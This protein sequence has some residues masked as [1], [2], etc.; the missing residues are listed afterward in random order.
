MIMTSECTDKRLGGKS[1][2][3]FALGVGRL[4]FLSL[5]GKEAE[6]KATAAWVRD[7]W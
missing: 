6:N 7:S 1:Y 2:V 4:C 3:S 5:S